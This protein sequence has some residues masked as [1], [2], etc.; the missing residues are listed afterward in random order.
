MQIQESIEELEAKLETASGLE[1]KY[2][3]YQLEA[4]RREMQAESLKVIEKELIERND[5]PRPDDDA[6]RERIIGTRN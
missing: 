6:P 3:E 5:N 2:I 4:A 1:G